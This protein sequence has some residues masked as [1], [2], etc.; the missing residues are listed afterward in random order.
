MP[1]RDLLK[2]NLKNEPA[3]LL[4]RNRARFY[5]Q[6]IGFVYFVWVKGLDLRDATSSAC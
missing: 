3:V 6:R 2:I 1:S 5:L 4:V